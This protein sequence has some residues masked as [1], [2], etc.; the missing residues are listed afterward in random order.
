MPVPAEIHIVAQITCFV[1]C[2][3]TLTF[4]PNLLLHYVHGACQQYTNKDTVLWTT[5]IN[6]FCGLLKRFVFILLQQF[7]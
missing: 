1:V 2:N 4:S 3:F 7:K 6:R 5:C